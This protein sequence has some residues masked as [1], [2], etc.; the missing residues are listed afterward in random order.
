M[1]LGKLWRMTVRFAYWTGLVFFALLVIGWIYL[2]GPRLI[3][4]RG[5][6]YCVAYPPVAAHKAVEKQGDV[7]IKAGRNREA[8]SYF[9]SAAERLEREPRQDRTD[10]Q[11]I[12]DYMGQYAM[13]AEELA[14]RGRWADAA[15]NMR[16]H[17]RA[18]AGGF[19]AMT[20]H[21]IFD[22]L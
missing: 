9:Q 4:P 7:L 15:D 8:Y 18:E 14:K 19:R 22:A 20:C 2:H 10:R 13:G 12:M 21:S 16:E 1:L 5:V 3:A 11:I 17:Y 6:P